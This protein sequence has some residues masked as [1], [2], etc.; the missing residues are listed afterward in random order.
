[1]RKV[2]QTHGANAPASL[3][4]VVEREP[5]DLYEQVQR[6]RVVWDD[7]MDRWLIGSYDLVRSTLR[8]DDKAFRRPKGAQA[9]ADPYLLQLTRCP[10]D[11][12]LLYGED[13]TRFHRWWQAVLSRSTCERWRPTR[14]RPI[15]HAI[16]DRFAE[17]GHAE[18][19]SEFAVQVP[20]RVIAS[21]LGLPWEDDEWIES[22]RAFLDAKSEYLLAVFDP[23]EN[24]EEIGRRA[25]AVTD[26][27]AERLKPYAERALAGKDLGDDLISMYAKDGPDIFPDWGMDDMMAGILT[28]F[29]AGSDTTTYGVS[30]GIYLLLTRPELQDELR[31]GGQEAVAA[32]VEEAL[33]I[34]A[35]A[36]FQSLDVIEDTDVGGVEMKKGDIVV[37]MLAAANLDPSH[38]ECPYDVKLDRASPRDH[39][40][41]WLGARACGGMWLARAELREMYTGLLERFTDLRLDPDRDPPEMHGW[42]TRGYWPL[43]VR[44]A[45][46]A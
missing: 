38:Y 31:A 28:A 9:M 39:A 7:K 33:R 42:T 3:R 17:R 35:V 27:L 40:T 36:H 29:F 5:W 25:V 15:V 34:L 44:F 18:L 13:H 10:R 20:I 11:I 37:P 6:D 43:N 26:E 14:I 22:C 24:M 41:F 45:S 8:R 46:E 2:T 16:I 32:F 19:R 30:N 1:V 12:T 23:P 4:D 21:V